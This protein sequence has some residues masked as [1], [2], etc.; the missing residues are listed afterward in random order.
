M[1]DQSPA[2]H[3]G[4][5]ILAASNFLTFSG[6]LIA[7]FAYW[8][9]RAPNIGIELTP[10]AGLSARRS[11]DHP[12]LHLHCRPDPAGHDQIHGLA[13]RPHL[14]PHPHLPAREPT[15][16]RRGAARPQPHLLG[17][18]PA[19]LLHLAAPGPDGRR[20]RHPH[21]L[22]DP[23]HLQDRRRHPHPQHAQ[24]GPECHRDCPRRA[25]ERRAR[26]HLPRGRH[27]PF[28]PAPVLQSRRPRNP[29]RH[30]RPI[31]PVFLDELWGSIF[32]FHG[33]RFFWKWP[34]A[35]PRN[36]SIWFGKPIYDPPDV[37]TVRQAVQDLGADAVARRKQRSIALPRAMIRNCRKSMFRWKIADSSGMEFSGGQLLMRTIILR[38]LL[39]ATCSKR[40][41]RSSASSCLP[42]LLAASPTRRY[43][44]RAASPPILITPRPPTP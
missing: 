36:V 16:A 10:R 15:R 30:R 27:H 17:R 6:M 2:E 25:P 31:V 41:K 21:Q 39:C 40:T 19:A 11:G 4:S 12:G 33:G 20:R 5:H 22:V 7:S 8:L 34:T 42:R 44:W 35:L 26:L 9:L 32:S 14:L 28:R 18:R 3:R 38:R 29:A 37:F 23:R 43:R 13:R 1:Q 24:G